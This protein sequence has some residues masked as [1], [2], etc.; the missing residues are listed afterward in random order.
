MAYQAFMLSFERDLGNK[1]RE[2]ET[3]WGQGRGGRRKTVWKQISRK[4]D[5]EVQ[6]P[7]VSNSRSIGE[8][9]MVPA[10]ISLNPYPMWMS[11]KHRTHDLWP[12][13]T[14]GLHAPLQSGWA[15]PY[16]LIFPA[17]LATRKWR[18]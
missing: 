5:Q 16:I 12:G 6:K 11:S 15:P 3:G 1:E 2:R 7:R 18:F 13:A 8:R 10:H 9:D 17:G 14:C 4:N